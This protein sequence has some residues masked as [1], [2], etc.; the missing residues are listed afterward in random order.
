MATADTEDLKLLRTLL[1][2]V[3]HVIS[4]QA[5]MKHT[6]ADT[7]RLMREN[8][9]RISELRTELAVLCARWT[10]HQD[11]HRRER[12]LMGTLSSLVSALTG[13]LAWFFS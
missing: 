3:N 11:L 1:E 5:E 7:N 4:E 2:R 10:D 13:F 8:S 12:V 6:Q 9:D